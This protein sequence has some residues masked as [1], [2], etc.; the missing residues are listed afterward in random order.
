MSRSGIIETA[1]TGIDKIIKSVWVKEIQ[2]DYYSGALLYEN[3]LNYILDL[4]L[5][6]WYE[7][8]FQTAIF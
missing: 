2:S 8:T 1:I 5:M 6:T 4:H 7:I 3:S